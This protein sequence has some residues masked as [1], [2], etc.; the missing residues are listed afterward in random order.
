M[1]AKLAQGRVMSRAAA[2]ELVVGYTIHNAQLARYECT[3]CKGKV[4]LSFKT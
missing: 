4:C 3:L 1:L 2:D